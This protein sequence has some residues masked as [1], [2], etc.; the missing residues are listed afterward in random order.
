MAEGPQGPYSEGDL[1][2]ALILS[3]LLGWAVV[4]AMELGQGC[5]ARSLASCPS[6][7]SSA[8]P[9]RY[10]SPSDRRSHPR[11]GYSAGPSRGPGGSVGRVHRNCH[12]CHFHPSRAAQRLS[13]IPRPDVQFLRP[14][15]KS[16]TAHPLGWKMLAL[17]HTVFILSGG[18]DRAPDPTSPSDRDAPRPDACF[19]KSPCFAGAATVAGSLQKF[20][21]RIAAVCK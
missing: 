1:R 11:P 15:G 19:A 7:R 2:R 17:D 6:L 14:R 13:D 8:C 3:A 12:R 21:K 9:S 5:G 4:T 10:L 16:W 20:Q 18:R